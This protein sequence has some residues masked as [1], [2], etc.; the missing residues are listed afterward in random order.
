MLI[1]PWVYHDLNYELMQPFVNSN[2]SIYI[3]N[4]HHE[5]IGSKA[6]EPVLLP[7]SENSKN[8]VIHFVWGD[9][10]KEL[11]IK[12]GVREELIY[13]TGNMRTDIA[14]EKTENKEDLAKEFD[15]DLKKEWILYTENRDRVSICDKKEEEHIIYL[16]LQEEDIPER[17][18]FILNSLN[19]TIKE[20]N[21]LPESFF[22]KYELIYRPHPGS[23]A[24]KDISN[25]VKVIYKYT[26]YD[27]IKVVDVNIVSGSTTIFESDLAGIPSIV[28]EPFP[29][30]DRQR[31]SGLE[32]YPRISRIN[33]MDES[34]LLNYINE[35]APKKIYERYIGKVDGN[36][37]ERVKVSV[38]SILENGIPNYSANKMKISK[39]RY[40]RKHIFQ[41]VTRIVVK[42]S[43]LEV[44]K[45]P[46]GAYRQRN[47]I[48]YR[49]MKN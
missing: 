8:S 20:F 25:N 41:K 9:F 28:H 38:L 39:K 17:K 24:S 1:V 46:R 48:P 7:S 19:E 10:F 45:Y 33:D 30:P 37:C 3:A 5:Q 35:I 12:T 36:S 6:T 2:P 44:V 47:E 26:I 32:F 49:I 13:V 18:A 14:F 29:Y 4:L 11:L 43:L 22:E 27:W 31:T 15:L 34:T 40:L 23:D 16:G 42:T 21:D